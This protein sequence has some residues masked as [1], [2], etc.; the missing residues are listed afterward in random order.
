MLFSVLSIN[1]PPH[2]TFFSQRKRVKLVDVSLLS[3]QKEITTGD[4]DDDRSASDIDSESGSE[5]GSGEI[6]VFF[7]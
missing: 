7:R 1:P 2:V 6:S 4:E 5:S 3:V